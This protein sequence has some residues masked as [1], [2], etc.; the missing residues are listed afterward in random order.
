[1]NEREYRLAL[2]NRG[3]KNIEVAKALGWYPQRLSALVNG[4]RKANNNEAAALCKFLRLPKKIL[5][6]STNLGHEKQK[7]LASPRRNT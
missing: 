7:N 6:P 3:L 4:Y 5:F 1:M 2:L